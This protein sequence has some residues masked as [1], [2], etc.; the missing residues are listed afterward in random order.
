MSATS[1]K[2]EIISSLSME[3]EDLWQELEKTHRSYQ[4]LLLRFDDLARRVDMKKCLGSRHVPIPIVGG[5][6]NNEINAISG[7]IEQ[8]NYLVQNPCSVFSTQNNF[9]LIF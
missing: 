9:S 3:N 2:D 4:D 1:S 8:K 7:L 5:A 6:V